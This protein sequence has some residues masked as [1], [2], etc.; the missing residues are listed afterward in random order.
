MSW[1]VPVETTRTDEQREQIEMIILLITLHIVTAQ[2][3]YFAVD[4][5]NEGRNFTIF[6]K[7][8]N[9]RV[10]VNKGLKVMYKLPNLNIWEI[11]Q[12]TREGLN[13]N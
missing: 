2:N 7:I 4:I 5:D 12:I 3:S 8:P 11:G 1:Y 9:C 6:S 13:Q 10:Y